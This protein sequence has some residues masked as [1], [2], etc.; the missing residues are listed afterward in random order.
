MPIP[1][2]PF[3]HSI[4]GVAGALANAAIPVPGVLST[5]VILAVIQHN[6]ASG[7]LVGLDPDAWTAGAGTIAANIA[8]D[9]DILTV[10]YSN[11]ELPA[12]S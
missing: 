3:E 12:Q 5:S 9:G 6:A 4:Q 10:I 8:T 2:L 11:T 1:G 7:E